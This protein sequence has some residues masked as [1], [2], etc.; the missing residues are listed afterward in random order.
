LDNNDKIETRI[1]FKSESF[2]KY[3]K[4]TSWLF[5][6]R[7]L[8]IIITLVVTIYV[9]RYL[10]PKDFG[11]LSYV[12]SFF[13]LFGAIAILG[14]E[15][16]AIR[17]LV[18]HPE[19]RDELVGTVFFL[20]LLSGLTAIILTSLVLLI[21]QEDFFTS[22]LILLASVSFLFQAFQSIEYYFRASV[23]AKYNAYAMFLSIV[24][25]STLK[26]I[27][28][29]LEAPILYFVIAFTTE[30]FLL[31]I[32]FV[33]VYKLNHLKIF[34]WK[35]SKELSIALLKDSWPLILT[36]LVVTIYVKIDQIMIKHMMHEEAVGLYAA[37][38]R[39]CEAWYFIPV[40]LC[41]SLFPA[42]INAKKVNEKLYNN[43]LQK[44][45]DI[46]VWLSIAIAILVTIFSSSIINILFGGEYSAS[47]QVL[48][49]YIWAGVAVFLGVASS[50]YLINE[51][52]TK[53]SFI[54][55]FIGMIL[56]IILNLILIPKFGIVGSA[57]ATLVSYTAVTFLLSFH[58]KFYIQFTMMLKSVFGI[59]ILKY[60][61]D[62]LHTKSKEKTR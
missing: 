53:L 52:L 48:T 38:V 45:Y 6:E 47:S 49:I 41:N 11:L 8:R 22:I 59:T 9:V 50:Q 4:N 34:T 55:A 12:I 15:N 10:G 26:V 14:L 24:L 37:A 60:A 19:K 16:I 35:Y 42:I 23:K 58:R 29:L 28:I 46:L 1:N 40:A 5:F 17:E 31:A 33:G 61:I 21:V 43:R 32:G 44:L 3:F 13:W 2:K 57:V 62:I 18:K 54:R 56:N 25:A 30:Y 7:V 39:I 51:N 27:L 20:R 36:G